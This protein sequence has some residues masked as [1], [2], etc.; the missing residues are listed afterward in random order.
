MFSLS[1][2]F[3]DS[4]THQNEITPAELNQ[5]LKTN[6][7]LVLDVRNPGELTG[8]LAKIPKAINIPLGELSGRIQELE[9]FKSRE[10]AVICHSGARSRQATKFLV[11]NGYNAVNVMGGMSAYKR[12]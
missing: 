6:A 11:K 3:G 5:K 7:V 4:D 9:K 12:G 2:L 1:S 10:I 8:H